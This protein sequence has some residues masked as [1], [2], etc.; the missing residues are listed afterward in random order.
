MDNRN[1]SIKMEKYYS[2]SNWSSGLSDSEFIGPRGSF[3]NSWGIDIHTTPGIIQPALLPVKESGTKVIDFCKFAVDCSSGSTFFF[4][5]AGNIYYRSV[6]SILV[7]SWGTVYKQSAGLA[8]KGAGEFDGYIYWTMNGNVN[9]IP[10]NGT[11]P[12]DV[13]WSWGSVNSSATYT[14]MVNMGLYLLIGSGTTIASVTETGTIVSSGIPDV[15]LSAL[16]DSY[17]ISS[18][19]KYGIDVLVGTKGSGGITG[20]KLL[21]WDL[22]SPA[23]TQEI[24]VPEISVDCFLVTNNM[25]LFQAGNKGQIYRYDGTGIEPF[26][27]IPEVIDIGKAKSAITYPQSSGNFFGMGYFGIST[28]QYL[29]SN[30]GLYSIGRKNNSYPIALCH[31]FP[32]SCGSIRQVNIGAVVGGYNKTFDLPYLL[33][34][35]FQTTPATYG[36]DA[37]FNTTTK[38]PTAYIETQS[39]SGD[40]F[41][42][43]TFQNY[44]IDYAQ[45]PA[46]TDIY[47]DYYKNNWKDNPEAHTSG[48]TRITLTDK[49]DYN[50]LV[51]DDK[52][53]A[54]AMKF[55]ITLAGGSTDPTF[56]SV[57]NF[58]TSFDER[59]IL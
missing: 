56:A 31:E 27:K 41:L 45:K 40:R 13:V 19:H 49:S 18:L 53:D 14:P 28:G 24:D 38:I 58:Y 25:T 7:A 8:T 21:R 12:T 1:Y 11:W 22:A 6:S 16:S 35:W 51:A 2:Q 43:K 3:S 23:Y 42:Q 52:I 37:V 57:S 5:D 10:I 55:R 17:S 44:D 34:A 48:T 47:L 46:T 9:R 33:F 15:A 36:I 59:S 29:A 54:G 30:Q 26:K 50:K 32:S 20:S 39:I 4:G